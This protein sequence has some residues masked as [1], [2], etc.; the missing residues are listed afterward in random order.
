M[1]FPLRARL[2]PLPCG[3]TL[4]GK[5]TSVLFGRQEKA[6]NFIFKQQ[7]RW[8]FRALKKRAASTG[9]MANCIKDQHLCA[10]SSISCRKFK[11]STPG[12]GAVFPSCMNRYSVCDMSMQA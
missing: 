8:R 6:I 7:A 9:K 2:T 4:V 1:D 12:L 11:F 5:G 3:N 10:K